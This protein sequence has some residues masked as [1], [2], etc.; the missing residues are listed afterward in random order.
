MLCPYVVSQHLSCLC[1]AQVSPLCV[2][3]WRHILSSKESYTYSTLPSPCRQLYRWYLVLAFV[4]HWPNDAGRASLIASIAVRP[5]SSLCPKLVLLQLLKP[6]FSISSVVIRVE[7][8]ILIFCQMQ[9]FHFTCVFHDNRKNDA[10]W[11]EAW[12]PRWPVQSDMQKS[13]AKFLKSQ[14]THS[15][16]YHS[17]ALNSCTL[18]A[19]KLYIQ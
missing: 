6:A 5:M 10:N 13:T 4:Y 9:S 1:S 14:M 19:I 17:A 11:R 2:I 15:V 12:I 7:T 16:A 8:A 18:Y 3:K